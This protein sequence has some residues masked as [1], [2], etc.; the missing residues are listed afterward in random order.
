MSSVNVNKGSFFPDVLVTSISPTVTKSPNHVTLL[1]AKILPLNVSSKITT[2]AV[3]C[4]R[5]THNRRSNGCNS[6]TIISSC[7]THLYAAHARRGR[8][9]LAFQ[10]W[11]KRTSVYFQN[12]LVPALERHR[13]T[14]NL[15]RRFIVAVILLTT[16]SG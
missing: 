5:R 2:L 12:K 11:S 15:Q 7:C 13:A 8:H 3:H 10:H 14:T 16:C 4:S 6:R 9:C 1:A